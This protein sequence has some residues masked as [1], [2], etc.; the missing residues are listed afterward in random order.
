MIL[1]END[2]ILLY[3]G[4]DDMNAGRY[5]V[6]SLGDRELPIV[7]H[8]DVVSGTSHLGNWHENIELLY[9][10]KGEGQAICNGVEYEVHAGDLVVINTNELHSTC[11]KSTLEYYCLIIDTEFLASNQFWIAEIEFES[12]VRS[13]Q[14]GA[15]YQQ[16]VDELQAEGPYQRAA[17]RA[18][19]LELVVYLARNHASVRRNR[20]SADENIKLA[21]GYLTSNY[22]EKITLEMLANEVGLSKCH[23]SRE[24][25][26]ATGMT[27]ISFLNAVRCRNA[28]KLLLKR[29]YSI[30]EISSRCGFESASYFSKT[31][32]SVMGCL[33]SEVRN[34]THEMQTE[35]KQ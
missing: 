7:F 34:G 28:K 35:G 16:I 25:K 23:F 15:L 20:S 22:A 13:P 6:H 29:N 24:F 1:T 32:K 14:V 21:I 33:P 26:R 9:C 19:L 4:T 27:V 11:S 12:L 31:Y 30:H 2:T 3:I 5:E 10:T 17:I 18:K 8:Y